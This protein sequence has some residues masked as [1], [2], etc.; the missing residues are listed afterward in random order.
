MA[1]RWLWDHLRPTERGGPQVSSLSEERRPGQG[2]SDN[3]PALRRV[4][5]AAEEQTQ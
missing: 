2:A 1:S 5:G 3:L 4:C